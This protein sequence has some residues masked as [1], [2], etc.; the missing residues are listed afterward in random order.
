M[1]KLL[2]MVIGLLVLCIVGFGAVLWTAG[3]QTIDPDTGKGKEYAQAF[4]ASIKGSCNSF[5]RM[6]AG[7]LAGEEDFQDVTLDIC[8][9]AA[10][11]TYDAFKNEP[12]IR[13]LSLASDSKTQAKAEEIMQ[14]CLDRANI[15]E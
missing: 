4:K 2:S 13:L 3:N 9:C 11:L 15:P 5:V 10:D 6:Q 7:S 14:E 12:P 8:E 1:I